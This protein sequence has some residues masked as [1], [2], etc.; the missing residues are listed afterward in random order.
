MCD[1][2]TLSLYYHNAI[3]AIAAHIWGV[4]S[5]SVISES[6]FSFIAVMYFMVSIS[7]FK[8][9]KQTEHRM[10]ENLATIYFIT[11]FEWIFKT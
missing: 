9:Q 1:A 11:V 5:D 6:I 2:G 7:G 10:S 3:L 8:E 4:I